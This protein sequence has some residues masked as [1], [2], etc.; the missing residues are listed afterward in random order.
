[1]NFVY[2]FI[3][4]FTFYVANGRSYLFKRLQYNNLHK[5]QNKS[6]LYTMVWFNNQYV[7]DI[8]NEVETNKVKFVFIDAREIFDVE[9]DPYDTLNKP[10]I[11]R[12][13]K[14]IGWYDFYHGI[15]E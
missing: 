2:I 1:M 10:L 3:F 8:L 11:Y 14:E 4:I 9:R 5:I 7:K 6:P 13:E 15:C 12:N